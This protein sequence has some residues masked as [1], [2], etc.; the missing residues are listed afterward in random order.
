MFVQ[1]QIQNNPLPYDKIFWVLVLI[2][3]TQCK[4]PSDLIVSSITIHFFIIIVFSVSNNVFSFQYK[5]MN[6][7]LSFEVL[8]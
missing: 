1:L 8:T 3:L 5:H 7:E 6:H 4:I 2:L